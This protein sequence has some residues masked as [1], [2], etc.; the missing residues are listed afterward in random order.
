M[1][2]IADNGS[3]YCTDPSQGTRPDTDIGEFSAATVGEVFSAI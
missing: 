1:G 3:C 2:T